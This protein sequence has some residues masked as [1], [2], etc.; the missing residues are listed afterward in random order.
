MTAKLFEQRKMAIPGNINE[1]CID[2]KCALSKLLNQML[3]DVKG[4]QK[5]L[6]ERNMKLT[7]I[8]FTN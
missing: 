2:L 1:Q 7:F 4:L 3:N 6:G 8:I 5:Q